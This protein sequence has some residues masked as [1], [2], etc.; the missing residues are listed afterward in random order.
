M[1]ANHLDPTLLPALAAIESALGLA[2]RPRSYANEPS[3]DHDIANFH[4][5]VARDRAWREELPPS[6]DEGRDAAEFF[7]AEQCPSDAN[8]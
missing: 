5:K 4:R 8:F 6:E 3:A 7:A 2:A 1:N